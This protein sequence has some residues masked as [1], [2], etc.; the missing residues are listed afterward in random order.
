MADLTVGESNGRGAFSTGGS[1]T[2]S[3]DGGMDMADLTVGE[4]NGR[5]A[6]STG[7]SSEDGGI[8]M[9]DLTVGESSGR[10]A[11]STGGSITVSEDGVPRQQSEFDDDEFDD[12]GDISGLLSLE[13]IARGLLS[14]GDSAREAFSTAGSLVVSEDGGVDMA[15]LTVGESNGRGAFST[16]GSITVS[17]DGVPRQESEFDD[18]GDISGLLSLENIARGLLSTGDSVREDTGGLLVLSE[19]GG[20]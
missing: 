19:D 17:E 8:D 14:T 13:N 1:I 12:D 4:S 18:D 2:I 5:G 11:F 16:G 7:G 3:E 9:A 15:D 6:F 10:G 20:A